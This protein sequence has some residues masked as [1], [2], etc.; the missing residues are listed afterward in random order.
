MTVT[1]RN[2]FKSDLEIHKLATTVRI[3]IQ[4]KKPRQ[5]I[6]LT[7]II[8]INILPENVREHPTFCH[9]TISRLFTDSKLSQA[10]GT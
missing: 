10:Q 2:N 7:V 6:Q 9:K 5:M 3:H 1:C 4:N 8:I